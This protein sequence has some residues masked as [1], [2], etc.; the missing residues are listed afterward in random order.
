MVGCECL[1]TPLSFDWPTVVT[2]IDVVPF[3][4]A[5]SRH[6]QSCR[7]ALGENMIFVDRAV[8]AI[9]G[10]TFLGGTIL[11]VWLR[12]CLIHLSSV[13]GGVVCRCPAPLYLALD[14]CVMC[15]GVCLY[16]FAPM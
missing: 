6:S 1:G 11:K 10:R 15:G 2:A 5:P 9:H 3:L 4:K 13:V 8:V 12:C 16:R 14:G 7:L